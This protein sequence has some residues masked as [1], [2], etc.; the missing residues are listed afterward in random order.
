ML[1]LIR[2]PH[3]LKQGFWQSEKLFYGLLPA[4]LAAVLL[5][6]TAARWVRAFRRPWQAWLLG[7]PVCFLIWTAEF[8]TYMLCRGQP[9]NRIRISWNQTT[10]SFDW[11]LGT[12]TLPPN[13][14]YERLD[15]IDSSVGRFR[16]PNGSTAVNHD[17]GELGGWDDGPGRSETLT[18]GARVRIRRH[19]A[20]DST[21]RR[22]PRATLSFPDSGCAK[23]YLELTSTEDAEIVEH[24]AKSF[25]PRDRKPA[26]L[27]PLLP[28][29][30]RSD[31]RYSVQPPIE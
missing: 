12:I 25:R 27:L 26:W 2:A 10:G 3:D 5:R 29:L 14:T 8:I 1:V 31:C 18:E 23:F 20:F 19:D 9:D 11:G 21:G 30:L 13:F 28:E 15:G 6:I 16:S 17:I 22:P 7:I 4:L 24:I